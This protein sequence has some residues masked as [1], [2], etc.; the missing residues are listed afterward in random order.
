MRVG[1]RSY[2]IHVVVSQED[3]PH[4]CGDKLYLCSVKSL[5][6]GSS[7]CV[8]G[9]EALTALT[10]IS[11]RIIPMRVGTRVLTNTN[12]LT[13]EDHPHACGDKLIML[14]G[15]GA[16]LGSSPCVWGQAPNKSASESQR[17]IIPM[18][19]GTRY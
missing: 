5:R 17:R 11:G 14:N 9:Q 7:P 2:L 1:T 18:R 19:V 10:T 12:L 15:A 3:H 6:L 4:A 8:W 16:K 13:C